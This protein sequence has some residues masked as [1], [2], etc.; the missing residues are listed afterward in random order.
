M[1]KNS[2]VNLDITNNADGFDISGGTTKRKLTISTSDINLIGGG[3]F[4]HTLPAAT[5]TIVGLTFA[6]SLTN[7]TL[8]TGTAIGASISPTANNTYDLGDTSNRFKKI[9]AIDLV[10]GDTTY[11]NVI[12]TSSAAGSC[13]INLSSSTFDFEVGTASA[14]AATRGIS[15]NQYNTGAEAGL[16]TI[17]KSRGT[18]TTTVVNP[19]GI[20]T[21]RFQAYGTTMATR[22]QINC[23]V[24]GTISGDTVPGQISFSTMNTVGSLGI[25][26]IISPAGNLTLG[27]A[28][29]TGVNNLFAAKIKE[30]NKI[31]SNVG[32]YQWTQEIDFSQITLDLHSQDGIKCFLDI[33]G[34]VATSTFQIISGNGTYRS[35]TTR[36]QLGETGDITHTSGNTTA[37]AH[38]ITANA[39]TTGNGISLSSSSTDTGARNLLNINNSS[40]AST[41]AKCFSITQAST[42]T[43]ATITHNATGTALDIQASSNSANK[44]YGIL[45]NIANAGAGLEYAFRFDGSEI[46]AAAVGG[47][48]D[49][50]IRVSIAGVDYFIPLYTA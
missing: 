43:P 11:S 7:K 9:Y 2:A 17:R 32:G 14:T 39:L 1:G 4:N 16:L 36:W 8:S 26:A 41:G 42:A 6:Q 22:A 25:R 37:N 29:G 27:S 50:K 10:V 5:D 48:Q 40:S 35:G 15:I 38:T 28:E 24:G 45:M 47:T 20:G 31:Q 3:A 19:D 21:I 44:A 30:S 33:D 49:K 13:G 23:T 34:G 18:G 12:N 46:V